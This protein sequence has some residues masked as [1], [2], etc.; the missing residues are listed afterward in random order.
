MKKAL[1]IRLGALGDGI[2]ASCCFPYLQK[3]G[4]EITVN[5]SDKVQSMLRY[6]PRVSNI[7]YH[8]RDCVP[9]SQLPKHWAELGKGYDKVVNLTG[10]MENNHLFAFPQ[11]EYYKCLG[12]RRW[13]SHN[14]NWYENQVLKAGYEPEG[15]VLGEIFFSDLEKRRAKKF[16]RMYGRKK[17]IVIWGL[18]GSSIHKVYRFFEPVA[19][20]FLDTYKDS[21]IIT[22]GGYE[23]RLLTFK[24][25]RLV[26]LPSMEKDFRFSAC[27]AKYSNLVVGP[28]TGILNVAGC[29]TTPKICFLTHSSKY[30]L[31]KHWI[32][33]Y[34]LQSECYCSPCYMLHKYIGIW[35]NHCQVS[36]LGWPKC[37][38]TPAPGVLFD[39]M[40]EVYEKWKKSGSR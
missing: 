28:E 29:F 31:T 38:D 13:N 9:I 19:R 7:I 14:V 23:G 21:V 10:T 18:S 24:H 25:E 22:S 33:D 36:D 6:N 11:D 2:I 37:T 5:C 1:V 35:R 30:N 26:D 8:E 39:T 20:K 4:Y 40:T 16:L 17:F 34:S 32:N 27:L 15:R 12:W 3:D